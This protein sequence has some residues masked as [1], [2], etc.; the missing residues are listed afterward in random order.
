M[1]ICAAFLTN[2]HTKEPATIEFRGANYYLP[3]KSVSILP[4][5][6]TVV[7][8]TQTVRVKFSF[9]MSDRVKKTMKLTKHIYICM[10]TDSFTTQ[11]KELPSFKSCKESEMEDVPRKHSNRG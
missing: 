8:N 11:C 3:E 2:N 4:N 1:N 9:Y 6:K 5:C 10:Q 7:Y